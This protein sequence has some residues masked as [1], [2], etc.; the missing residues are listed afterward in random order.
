MP[1]EE[2][3]ASERSLTMLASGSAVMHFVAFTA[4]GYVALESITYGAVAGVLSALGSFFFLPWF[5]GIS[6]VQSDDGDQI[7][8]AEAAAR[9]PAS[10]QLG[11]L[12]GGLEA[13]SVVM[14]AL[15]FATDGPNLLYG[16]AGGLAAALVIHLGWSMLVNR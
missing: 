12:G 16:I 5:I 14:L 6:S 3:Q 11:T 10:T 13:G 8:F 1:S 15:G 2:M 7:P 4:V 9:V